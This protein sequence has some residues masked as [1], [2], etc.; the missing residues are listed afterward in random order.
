[1]KHISAK[2]IGSRISTLRKSRHESQEN[3]AQKISVSRELISK[4][5]SGSQYPSV[6][7]L[8]R[9]SDHYCVPSDFLLFGACNHP[10]IIEEI[11]HV[12]LILKSVQRKL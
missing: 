9:L 10:G 3:L 4:I 11:D 1:M 7:V 8:A 5:E 6:I 2:D 12:I